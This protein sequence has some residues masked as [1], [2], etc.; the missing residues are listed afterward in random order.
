M[1][2]SPQFFGKYGP[3]E[4]IRINKKPIFIQKKKNE[5]FYRAYITYKY[6][7]SCSIAILSINGGDLPGLQNLDA[8]FSA[9]KL[10]KFFVKRKTCLV[11][12][13]NFAHAVD[14]FGLILGNNCNVSQTL[15]FETQKRFVFANGVKNLGSLGKLNLKELDCCENSEEQGKPSEILKENGLPDWKNGVGLLQAAICAQNLEVCPK[16]KK[17]EKK[18]DSSVLFFLSGVFEKN[19]NQEK[20]SQNSQRESVLTL[21]CPEEDAAQKFEANTKTSIPTPEHFDQ[22]AD[23]SSKVSTEPSPNIDFVRPAKTY[24][25]FFKAQQKYLN[26]KKPPRQQHFRA[27]AMA[28]QGQYPRSYPDPCDMSSQF[29]LPQIPTQSFNPNSPHPTGQYFYCQ[30]QGQS[31]NAES[32][33]RP[34]NPIDD[35]LEKC[36]C[37]NNYHARPAEIAHRHQPSQ[38]TQ[39][40]PAPAHHSNFN[41]PVRLEN[42]PNGQGQAFYGFH[43]E[44]PQGSYIPLGPTYAMDAPPQHR[45]PMPSQIGN[46]IPNKFNNRGFHDSLQANQYFLF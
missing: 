19:Q 37:Y 18:N 5:K 39:A 32:Y 14:D 6:P 27:D 26:P 40:R 13:C 3:I 44:S 11:K 7:L 41:C 2:G 1:L 30:H 15:G 20:S 36:I 31:R 16:A 21:D 43:R 12:D 9:S 35:Y 8:S 22:K 46:K 24:E 42:S 45:Q 33:T 10:C 23:R 29:N 38:A 34:E 17:A 28:S 25:D 4:S